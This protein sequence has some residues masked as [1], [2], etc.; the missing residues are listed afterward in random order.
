MHEL[1]ICQ[2]ITRL[3]EHHA[4]GRT[5]RVVRLRVGAL[6]QIVPD[7]LTYCWGLV[8]Q[9]SDLASATLEIERV[10]AAIRCARCDHVHVLTE[11]V[12]TC[13]ACQGRE[14]EIVSGDEFLITSLD[15]MEA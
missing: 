8:T 14:I 12:L 3:V 11:P 5:V 15:L 2:S 6:R 10:P 7:T 1:S 9:G 4:G 13:P